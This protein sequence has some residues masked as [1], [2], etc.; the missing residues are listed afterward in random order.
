MAGDDRIIQSPILDSYFQ[1]W[2]IF[3]MGKNLTDIRRDYESTPMTKDDLDVSPFNQFGSW[4]QFA[5]D[6]KVLDATSMLLST[7]T[8]QGVPSSRVVLL[9]K[10]DE[11]GFVWFTDSR[12]QKGQELA[13]NP[14]AAILF[15]WRDFSRQVRIQG[16]V[17]QLPAQE[18]EAY[19]S[20][21]PEGS[22]YSAASSHQSS[23]VDSRK[24][25]ENAVSSMVEKYPDNTVPRP[26]AWLGYRL[27]PYSFEFWQGQSNRLHDRICYTRDDEQWAKT[28]LSP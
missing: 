18:A 14:N 5:I 6:Q 12:S 2:E 27:M 24:E 10:Y 8:L 7:A 23:I 16:L 25:L 1:D 28:R 26:D 13:S 19:F 11:E 20:S 3:T 17:E 22:R 21:R 15:H 4:L 9:K